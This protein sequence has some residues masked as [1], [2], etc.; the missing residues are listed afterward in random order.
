M[1]TRTA[2]RGGTPSKEGSQDAYTRM[3]ALEKDL[4]VRDSQLEQ[5]M[6]EKKSLDKVSKNKE[7]SL[8]NM[9]TELMEAKKQISRLELELVKKSDESKQLFEQTKFNY[10]Q[11]SGVAESVRNKEIET[12]RD[13]KAGIM[14][15]DL[16]HHVMRLENEV[17]DRDRVIASLQEENKS[18]DK[19]IKQRE[20]EYI[21]L[22]DELQTMKKKLILS[23]DPALTENKVK[24]LMQNIVELQEENRL[25]LSIQKAKT[26]AI[27][28]LT[29][30]LSVRGASDE[31][32]EQMRL[33]AKSKDREISRRDDEN[34]RLKKTIEQQEEIVSKYRNEEVGVPVHMWM[35]ERRLLQ[36]E[37]QKHYEL[38]QQL[39][40]TIKG[41]KDRINQ[42]Q[43]SLDVIVKSYDGGKSPSAA[44]RTFRRSKSLSSN[45][46]APSL[47]NTF[48]T[49]ISP[50]MSLSN[51]GNFENG[52]FTDQSFAPDGTVPYKI[53]EFLERNVQR[54]SATLNAKEALL[55]EKDEALEILEKRIDVTT[56]ARMSDNKRAKKVEQDLQRECQLLKE[57]LDMKD[58]EAKE[59]AF[60]LA[61]MKRKVPPKK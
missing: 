20:D 29:Q 59:R 37:A 17:R 30:E 38:K 35:E 50:P 60:E 39:E 25:L 52:S 18:L 49:D 54:M 14:P 56:K 21:L 44:L 34:E 33:E 41:Q 40:K 51:T 10:S 22:T 28:E 27:E 32:L 42:L 9:T 26:Q 6:N 57:K 47:S 11:V 7:T 12:V 55:S 24:E 58:T 36:S 43:D 23:A 1:S 2:A 53:Y 3:V 61:Q 16:Y 31:L 19:L 5:I 8:I 48:N 46:V 13:G 15:T 4:R 45:S